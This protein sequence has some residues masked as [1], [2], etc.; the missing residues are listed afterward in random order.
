[1]PT[2]RPLPPLDPGCSILPA[3]ELGEWAREAFITPGGLLHNPDHEHLEY[4]S[5]LWLWAY[6]ENFKS[7][8]TVLGDCSIPTPPMSGGAWGR[9]AYWQQLEEWGAAGGVD[10]GNLDGTVGRP[11][12]V[13]RIYAPFWAECDD[14]SACALAEHEL[15]HAGQD[16]DE[17]EDPAFVA[18]TGL[19]KFAIKGH[20]I[21]E[22]SGVLRRYGLATPDLERF[23]LN[24][25][26]PPTVGRA[27]I[28]Q[29][30]GTCAKAA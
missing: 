17:N 12:F 30:C 28:S 19:P 3:P 24:L 27:S 22:H 11:D 25:K 23:S 8:R 9:A 29:A 7:R 14:L 5:I 16:V 21:E 15:Y 6:T 13:I 4:A 18:S 1:M 2:S 26:S 10:T 20:D